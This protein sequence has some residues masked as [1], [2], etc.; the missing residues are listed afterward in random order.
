MRNQLTPVHF[1]KI[2]QS[3]VLNS[4]NKLILFLYHKLVLT[5]FRQDKVL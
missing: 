2:V 1:S 3:A 4:Q 5:L